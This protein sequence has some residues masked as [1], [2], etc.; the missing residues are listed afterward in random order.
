MFDRRHLLAA[1]GAGVAAAPMLTLTSEAQA[2]PFR[3][4]SDFGYVSPKDDPVFGPVIRGTALPVGGVGATP[5]RHLEVATAFRLLFDAPRGNDHMAV[6]HYFK[7]LSEKNADGDPYNYEWPVRANPLITG[8][9]A[10]TNT[11]PS[12][13]DQTSWC[14][15]FV[16]FCLYAAGKK[17]Q[18]SALSGAYRSY[19]SSTQTPQPGDL[20]VFADHG[21]AGREGH[22]HVAFFLGFDADTKIRVLGG[23]QRGNTGS[24]GAV[25]VTSFPRTGATMDLHSFRKVQ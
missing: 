7:D 13:G 2:T 14:A 19:S 1:G 6:A 20:V 23:N 21:Q 10:M 22:G 17:T 11:N 12:D 15:A 3:G 25:T 16:S 18:F 4:P 5:S 24:T 8:L 9:F